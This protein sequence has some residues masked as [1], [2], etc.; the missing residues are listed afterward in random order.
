M[1]APVR[2]ADDNWE[3]LL[4]VTVDPVFGSTGQLMCCCHPEGI[5]PRMVYGCPP[6]DESQPAVSHSTGAAGVAAKAET[7]VTIRI[8]SDGTSLNKHTTFLFVGIS[9]V[10][11]LDRARS[12]G[13][14]GI[15]GK[16]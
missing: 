11:L 8:A 4:T 1:L 16:C 3:E 6:D 7:L 12:K 9:A 13:A 14:P 10:L 2:N 5:G 15:R